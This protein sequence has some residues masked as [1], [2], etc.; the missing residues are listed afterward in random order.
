MSY[1]NQKPQK[2]RHQEASNFVPDKKE[3][4][5]LTRQPCPVCKRITPHARGVCSWHQR[6]EDIV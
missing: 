5:E 6:I 2:E 4:S 3:L 1:S